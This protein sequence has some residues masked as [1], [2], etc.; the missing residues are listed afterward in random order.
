MNQHRSLLACIFALVLGVTLWGGG[1]ATGGGTS[2]QSGDDGGGSDGTTPPTDASGDGNAGCSGGK[3]KCG[4]TCTITSTDPKNCGKC[5]TVCSSGQVCSQGHCS[6]GCSGGE[7]LCG[8][9]A[10]A[11]APTMEAGSSGDAGAA[12]TGTA[13]P[14][15]SGAAGMVDAGAPYCANLNSDP[16]NCGAC[17]N[18]C[19][20]GTCMNGSCSAGSCPAGQV[21]CAASGTCIPMG[22]CCNTGECTI[23]GQVCSMPGGVCACPSGEKQCMTNMSCISNAA[24]CTNADCAMDNGETC[25]MAGGTCTCPGTLQCCTGTDCPS[26]PHVATSSCSTSATP[27][28]NKCSVATCTTGCYDLDHT[29]SDG[30][31][32]CD[33]ANGHTCATATPGNMT[34]SVGTT[35]SLSGVIPEPTGG[36]WFS[37]VMANPPANSTTFHALVQFSANPS[38]EFVFDIVQNSCAGTALTCGTET[39]TTSTKDTVWESQYAAGVTATGNPNFQPIPAIGTLFIHVYRASTTNPATCDQYTLQISE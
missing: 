31:E 8:G 32:C 23:T 17:G 18:S 16:S 2:A 22:T 27:P 33:D 35:L 25:A 13:S 14:V 5:G 12:D 15:D 30:C 26:E 20:T 6:A 10:E 24:C 38:N 4:S 39:G 3:T 34:V 37:V 28:A 21:P 7:T 29:F 36:D 19:G 11:G 9:P 1:C